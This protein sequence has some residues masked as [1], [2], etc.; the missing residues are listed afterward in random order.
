MSP[1]PVLALRAP[2]PTLSAHKITIASD[3]HLVRKAMTVD[4]KEIM[5]NIGLRKAG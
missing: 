3:H 5:L 4:R 1:A 2:Y